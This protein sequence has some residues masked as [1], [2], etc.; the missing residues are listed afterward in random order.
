MNKTATDKQVPQADDSKKILRVDWHTMTQLSIF[1]EE[2]DKFMKAEQTTAGRRRNQEYLG[3]QESFASAYVEREAAFYGKVEDY[4]H[5][6][7]ENYGG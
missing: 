1:Y 2:Y 4:E 7:I 5:F 6:G 3:G